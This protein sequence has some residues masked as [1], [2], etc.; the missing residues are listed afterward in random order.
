MSSQRKESKGKT[1]VK[2]LVGTTVV[3]GGT[4]L[5]VSCQE[6]QKLKREQ[7]RVDSTSSDESSDESS[8]KSSYKSSSDPC[9]IL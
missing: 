7:V 2:A 8:Y 1:V 9:M 6:A 3:V 4:A 5:A